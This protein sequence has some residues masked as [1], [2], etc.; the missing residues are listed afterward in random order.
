M[1]AAEETHVLV[2]IDAAG[3]R[4]VEAGVD[5]VLEVGDVEDEGGG[6]AVRSGTDRVDLIKLVVEEQPLHVVIDDPS[7]V[8]VLI[9]GG[10]VS[11]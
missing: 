3:G 1:K 7:L 4:L 9:A 5:G 2:V 10:F 11:L 8:S 6:V